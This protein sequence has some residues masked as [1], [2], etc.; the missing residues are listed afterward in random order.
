MHLYF[1]VETVTVIGKIDLE[2]LLNG[3]VIN[4][5]RAVNKASFLKSEN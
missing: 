4:D 1:T 3:L 2:Y 5:N